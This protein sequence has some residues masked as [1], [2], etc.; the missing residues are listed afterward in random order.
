[1]TNAQAACAA[2][3]SDPVPAGPVTSAS[4]YSEST[5][6]GYYS[7]R[8]WQA[9]LA[10]ADGWAQAQPRNANAWMIL[11]NA[12]GVG[13]RNDAAAA[14]AF[15]KTIAVNPSWYLPYIGLGHSYLDQKCY[16]LAGAALEK[17]ADHNPTASNW[18]NAAAAY[19]YAGRIDLWKRPFGIDPF[20]ASRI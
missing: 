5:A 6:D 20:S 14:A 7:A 11:G 8:N 19:S 15:R 1:M 16:D 2:H 13:I 17:A 3:A 4:S 9:L 10:Y 18:K 12:Y